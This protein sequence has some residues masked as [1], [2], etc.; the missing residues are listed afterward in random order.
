MDTRYNTLF[1]G[2]VL[3]EYERLD[4]TNSQAERLLKEKN[5]AEG[6]VI[7]TSEQFSGRGQ[8]GNSWFSDSNKNIS[9]SIILQPK[10]DFPKYQFAL[11]QIVS[12]GIRDF[13]G[14][15]LSNAKI[16]WP[17]D[18]MIDNK[19]VAGVLIQNSISK[20]QISNSIVG[21]GINVNQDFFPVGLGKPTS[22]FLETEKQYDIKE[23]LGH[24]FS[25]IEAWYLKLKSGKFKEIDDE[26]H[27]YLYLK[28]ELHLF[29]DSKGDIFK[30]SIIGVSND[31]RLNVKTS[32]GLKKFMFKEISLV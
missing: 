7:F 29:K 26:Y 24:L 17:N 21:I 27:K 15:Y 30:G 22:M 23:L 31:G 14:T 2:K 3:L 12:L 8:V 25:N 6:T 5:L 10:L 20:K 9:I 11:N 13:I 19:K 18:I 1:I 32:N 28:N 4:S 16:K